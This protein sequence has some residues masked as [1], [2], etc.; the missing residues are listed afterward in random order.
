MS[1][2]PSQAFV[3]MMVEVA[4][5]EKGNAPALLM[6]VSEDVDSTWF[7]EA[8]RVLYDTIRTVLAEGSVPTLSALTPR[9]APD[10]L[11][12]LKFAVA[13]LRQGD[14]GD[15]G[16]WP[17]ARRALR[18]EATKRDLTGR[19]QSGVAALKEGKLGEAHTALVT[20]Q[21]GGTLTITRQSTF[22]KNVLDA[23]G[24]TR[25]IRT[26]WDLL[27]KQIGGGYGVGGTH[28]MSIVI[29]PTGVGKSTWARQQIASF[30]E[31]GHRVLY[32]AGE[33]TPEN[34]L[35][36][37]YMLTA[38]ISKEALHQRH[39]TAVER[40]EGARAHLASF[41]DGLTLV[42]G[43]FS[44]IDVVERAAFEAS[45]LVSDK[46]LGLAEPQAELMVIVDNLDHAVRHRLRGAKLAEWQVYDEALGEM[47]EAASHSNYHLMN[48]SQ[49]N[50]E[51]AKLL[52]PAFEGDVQGGRRAA[53]HAALIISLWRPLTAAH[54]EMHD[55][56]QN[57]H[58]AS[59]HII[60][61]RKS[62]A[63]ATD[64]LEFDSQFGLWHPRGK[65]P[66]KRTFGPK[67]L[68][69]NPNVL[70]F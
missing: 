57:P 34:V 31:D 56:A 32:F 35:H 69:A 62:R 55:R 36:D 4:Q 63:G 64:E 13:Q 25:F 52:G 49:P 68:V 20:S 9:L 40:F 45:R 6:G 16:D 14:E 66:I 58:I 61:V 42:T 18:D 22:T 41:R 65:L 44:D 11:A 24:M 37:V 12:R 53:N 28:A 1:L 46:R 29:A 15:F 39:P 2:T 26:P 3:A 8:D 50:A 43:K 59:K 23:G 21:F 47:A 7:P 33:A 38:G 5:E 10:Q 19:I 27:S 67:T 51:G 17:S 60:A 54:R 70:P 30:I 48:L